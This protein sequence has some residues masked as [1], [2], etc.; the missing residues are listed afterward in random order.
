MIDRCRDG[1]ALRSVERALHDTDLPTVLNISDEAMCA[2]LAAL[3]Q[4]STSTQGVPSSAPESM[5]IAVGVVAVTNSGETA[6][7]QIQTIDT[8]VINMSGSVPSDVM[9]V[10][11]NVPAGAAAVLADEEHDVLVGGEAGSMNSG[12]SPL[13]DI[14]A[15]NIVQ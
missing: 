5:E 9:V 11:M 8:G 13:V 4:C 6:M 2:E 1:T 10:A 15:D 14:S 3:G 7:T 12:S